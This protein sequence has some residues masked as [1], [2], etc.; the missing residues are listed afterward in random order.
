[1]SNSLLQNLISGDSDTVKDL[2]LKEFH[3]L[4]SYGNDTKKG[5]GST[6]D[7]RI[8]LCIHKVE[9]GLIAAKSAPLLKLPSKFE[10]LPELIKVSRTENIGLTPG[11]RLP[12]QKYL[13]LQCH[14]TSTGGRLPILPAEFLD[15]ISALGK[16]YFIIECK[17]RSFFHRN[18]AIYK[19]RMVAANCH[20]FSHH[21]LAP[22]MRGDS[23]RQGGALDLFLLPQLDTV[24][25][26]SAKL[27]ELGKQLYR[28]D[29]NAI[30]CK[31]SISVED[32]CNPAPRRSPSGRT[33]QLID[34]TIDS[35]YNFFS[36][37]KRLNIDRRQWALLQLYAQTHLLEGLNLL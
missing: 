20:Y 8:S 13:V 23:H 36:L 7:K 4:F 30:L 32:L 31:P 1:M 27:E 34:K 33:L 3:D 24:R 26:I 5:D 6:K 10:T 17:S 21:C 28:E 16:E 22:N 18:Y 29:K 35:L 37:P 12:S 14:D 15:P 19:S 2:I 11:L 9:K 25:G